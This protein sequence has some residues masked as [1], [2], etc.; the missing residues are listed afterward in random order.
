MGKHGILELLDGDVTLE[1]WLGQLSFGRH[2][3]TGLSTSS[4]SLMVAQAFRKHQGKLVVLLPCLKEAEDLWSDLSEYI[5]SS[6]LYAFLADDRLAVEYRLYSR[7]NELSRL[8]ALAFLQDKTA[9]GVLITTLTAIGLPLSNPKDY[10][11]EALALSL[12]EEWSLEQLVDKL[13][14]LGYERVLQV[15]TA[16]QYSLR[17][18]ILDVYDTVA[19]YPYRIE[20]FGD[21]IDGIR[22]F[23]SETQL[24]L[25]NQEHALIHPAYHAIVTSKKKDR[26]KKLL[27]R[28]VELA[29]SDAIR[30][31]LQDLL[32]LLDK[33]PYHFELQKHRGLF[34]EETYCLLHYLP[35]ETPIIYDDFQAINEHYD[36]LQLEQKTSSIDSEHLTTFIPQLRYWVD[37]FQDLRSYQPASFLTSFHRGL[38][39]I[40]FDAIHQLT[41][42]PMQ[43]FFNQFPLLVDE[44]NRYQKQQVTVLLQ[45][46]SLKNRQHLHQTFLS[47]GL[48]LL[49]TNKEDIVPAKTQIFIGQLPAGFHL[50]E[51]KLVLITEQ[52]IFRRKIRRRIKQQAKSNAKRLKD[53]NELSPG[54]Y[55]VHPIHGIGQ[56]LGIETMTVSGMHRDYLQ[57]QY[58]KSDQI[59]LPI[60]Q[61]DNLSRYISAEGKEPKLNKLNDGRF[62]KVKQKISKQVE[63]IADDLLK[64]Y[65][66]RHQLEGFS[67]SA[68][69]ANQVAFDQ[70]FSYIETPDQL[71]SIAEVKKD[72]QSKQPMDR[73]LVGDVG[74]GKTEVAMRAAFKAVN[75]GKQVAI[76]VP[77][78]VLAHQHFL[79]FKERFTNH[80]VIIAELS[81]FKTAKEQ[82][83]MIE[84]TKNERVDI[85]IGTHRLLSKD[86]VFS[87][88]GLIVIDEEQRFGVKHKERLKELKK[89]VDVLTLT[90]T[91][92][93][94]TLHMSMLGI[95]DLS[96]VET[97]PTNRFP[98]QTYITQ[99]HP[100]V[101]REASLREMHRGGQLF[102]VYNR[103]DTIEQKVAE[104]K[105]LIPEAEIAFVHGQMSE[106]ELEETLM[107]FLEGHYHILVA[108]TI[109]ETGIDIANVNT[110]F[111]ED[112]DRLG[113]STLYQLRGRVGRSNRLAYAYLMY[114]PDKQLT[115]IAEKRL[116]AIRG[117]TE[118]GS[119][120]KIAMQDLAIRGAGN[121]LGASQSGFID[122]VGFELYSQ[123]LE[124]AIAKK[125]GKPLP[126]SKHHTQLNLKIDA[127]LPADYITDERQKITLYKRIRDIT[128]K[129]NYYFLQDEL[130]DRFGDYPKEVANLLLISLLK[131]TL[132]GLFVDVLEQTETMILLRFA[133]KAQTLFL[134][135]DYFKALSATRLKASI[136]D[137]QGKV[138][139][140]F[141][142]KGFDETSLLEELLAFAE[143]FMTIKQDKS[144]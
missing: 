35:S 46:N 47:Y 91:P 65:A 88:L 98:V 42:Y 1:K 144:L 130:I 124:E 110:L 41:Q 30:T 33:T 139:V 6:F 104:L 51:Q 134:S 67:F 10:Q 94:R 45:V 109:I 66:E 56:F 54:D 37:C 95:R 103:V 100:N 7:E 126:A 13:V 81:R 8:K 136:S 2:L 118:L 53:Y 82:K 27:K 96:L 131:T 127:Y 113:L 74:F 23:D 114:R 49:V 142:I 111:I 70:E 138:E 14:Y 133:K 85:L 64:L 116:E 20:L 89:R 76:L 55:V 17:G 106:V 75:D 84:D 105:A 16:G 77:T 39:T 58:Q 122:S 11:T 29:K 12:E 69:D 83:Q 32:H 19:S 123:L 102:Y 38:G 73:L 119:G 40:T 36:Q 3:V 143:C 107:A 50:A 78:T 80:A 52:E 24:S 22:F 128:T 115:E 140:R 72:M 43:A 93:P 141:Q 15:E 26:A 86:V 18:D 120:F 34:E 5:D 135:Q 90:A 59:A 4:K 25:K 99:T 117:F 137:Y 48:E 92:I 44:I 60:E 108:T 31:Q 71:R 121:L 21:E 112:A 79:S 57:I 9:K 87:D 62:Q 97:A 61:V 28:Q 125:Q 132:E 129:E 101:I 63:D 68:D